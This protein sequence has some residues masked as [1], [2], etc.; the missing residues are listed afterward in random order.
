VSEERE[1]MDNRSYQWNASDYAAHSSVQ[2]QWAEELIGKLE[3]RGDEAV[4]DIGCGDGKVTAKIAAHLPHGFVVGI[5]NSV[6]MIEL[7]RRNFSTNTQP[8]LSFE[9]MDARE[10]QYVSRFDLAFS[11]ASLHWVVNHKPVL[12]GVYNSLKTNG[13]ILFQMGGKGNAEDVVE[14]FDLLMGMDPW[15]QYFSGFSFPYGFFSPQEYT[16]F[17]TGA[18]FLPGRLELIPKDMMQKGREGLAGWIR[19][20]WLPY[21]Q[22]VPEHLRDTFVDEVVES[23]LRTHPP[24]SDGMVHIRMMRLEI[25]AIRQ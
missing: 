16:R 6:D 1:A 15:R 13:R 12:D 23:Y 19:T 21:I 2:F 17:L 5:D 9:P 24:D 8:N 22:R 18:G 10:I 3:L 4:L 14:A 20:T 11:N 7:A 25:E